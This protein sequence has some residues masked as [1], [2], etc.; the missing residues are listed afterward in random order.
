MIF[1]AGEFE[2]RECGQFYKSKNDL[3]LHQR[4][5]VRKDCPICK[6]PDVLSGKIDLHLWTHKNQEEKQAII[7]AEEFG[8]IPSDVKKGL[9]IRVLKP[10]RKC[11]KCPEEFCNRAQLEKHERAQHPEL[12]AKWNKVHGKRK[13]RLVQS[14]EDEFSLSETESSED[15]SETE[16][17]E[18]ETPEEIVSAVV[19]PRYSTRPKTRASSAAIGKEIEQE[20]SSRIFGLRSRQTTESE[21][22]LAKVTP[23]ESPQVL[24][25][26]LPNTVL[27]AKN[28]RMS[29]KNAIECELENNQRIEV[30]F[31]YPNEPMPPGII[32]IEDE[33]SRDSC[34]SHFEIDQSSS[35]A[36][37]D[38]EDEDN[39]AVN[40]TVTSD[41]DDE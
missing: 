6:R 1:F 16:S 29:D 2:C 21:K 7:D 19:S 37:G 24:L 39:F 17:S 10:N 25:S 38:S 3:R 34:R 11:E 15:R 5:H 30:P 41:D 9:G 12:R 13:K 22:S 40:P 14:D 23:I 28:F 20:P 36:E 4:V 18:D 27:T 32:K 8:K 26:R 31:R 35:S 33:N